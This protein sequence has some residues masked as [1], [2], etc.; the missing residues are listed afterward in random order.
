MSTMQTKLPTD[1]WVVATWDEFIQT[2]EDPAYQKTKGYYYNG[3]MRIETIPV[4]P[5]HAKDNGIIAIAVTLFAACK[6]ILLNCLDNCT[7]RKTGVRECQ[8]DVSYYIGERAQMVPTGTA[9]ANLDNTPAPDLAIEIADSSLADDKGE[10][11][12][13]YE[14]IK[15]AEYW[16]VDVQKAE[17]IAFEIIPTGGSRRITESQILPGLQM[18]VLEETLRRSRQ[19]AHSQVVHWLLTQFQL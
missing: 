15:I 7:Y 11:R 5:D 9:I 16:I 12:L 14:D 18:A 1:T 8:P 2:I 13:L 19:M 4:S 3:K 6:G 10:K 17:I